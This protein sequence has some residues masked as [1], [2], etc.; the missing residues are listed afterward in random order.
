MYNMSASN[1]L[2]SNI[3]NSYLLINIQKIQHNLN[4]NS[5]LLPGGCRLLEIK[6][7]EAAPMWLAN[8]LSNEKI[9]PQSYSKY[10]T[11]YTSLVKS[12]G[13]Q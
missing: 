5:K 13:D 7:P 8:I 2:D 9:F 3:Y 1:I 12:K 11:Y 10:G 6:V 4:I